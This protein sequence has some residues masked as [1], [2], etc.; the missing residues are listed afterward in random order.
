ML[1]KIVKNTRIS[2][3]RAFTLLELICVIA[4]IALLFALCSCHRLACLKEL[5]LVLSVPQI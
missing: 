1:S 2:A 3:N 4:V 5:Q